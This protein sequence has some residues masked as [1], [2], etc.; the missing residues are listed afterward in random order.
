MK[1]IENFNNYI[2][3]IKF[4]IPIIIRKRFDRN[5]KKGRIEKY[6]IV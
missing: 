5:V 2:S 1:K 3:K 6:T 4:S